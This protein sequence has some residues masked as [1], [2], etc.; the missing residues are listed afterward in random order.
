LVSEERVVWIDAICINQEDEKEKEWHVNCMDEIYKAAYHVVAWLGQPGEWEIELVERVKEL[1]LASGKTTVECSLEEVQM[2][3]KICGNGYW[4]RTW[5]IQE[6]ILAQKITVLYGTTQ[7]SFDS[8]TDGA[9]WKE[10]RDKN[11]VTKKYF[12]GMLA[13]NAIRLRQLRDK[14]GSDR[15]SH[16]LEMP[17]LLAWIEHGAQS[18]CCIKTD[19]I[20]ALRSFAKRCCRDVTPVKYQQ[21]GRELFIALTKHHF[22]EH[23]FEGEEWLLIC[24][25]VEFHAKL[26][27][28]YPVADAGTLLP[29]GLGDWKAMGRKYGFDPKFALAVARVEMEMA[30][31]MVGKATRSWGGFKSA[32]G[33]AG[34]HAMAVPRAAMDRKWRENQIKYWFL[35]RE[36]VIGL[37]NSKPSTFNLAS[38]ISFMNVG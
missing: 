27:E 26:L 19:E 13:S 11:F 5:V 23:R 14:L 24:V 1:F 22:A 35:M 38:P 6:V 29:V 2:L 7:L 20:F 37:V 4:T 9:K 17:L 15:N 32:L 31:Q 34:L 33:L 18:E 10:F 30:S 8:L 16:M 3:A 25:E 21:N 12:E 28:R 36:H